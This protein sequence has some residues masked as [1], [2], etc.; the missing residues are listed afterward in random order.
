MKTLQ[1]TYTFDASAQEITIGTFNPI[2]LE[3]VM[4]ITNV[5][6]NII[7]Y[8]FADPT[9]GGTVA[10]DTLTLTY[11]TTSMADGDDLQIWYD[12]VSLS[13]DTTDLATSA[14]QLAAGHT[15]DCDSTDV[16]I[17]NI[18]SDEVFVRG[19]QAAGSPVDNEVVTV[20]GISSMTP[21]IVTESSPI[22]G[23]ATEAKQL[24][25]GHTV[26]CNGTDVTI[27]NISTNEVYVRGGGT[28]GSPTDGEVVVVQGIAGADPVPVTESSPISGFATEAKQLAAGHTVDC[29]GTDVTIDNIS[30]NEV[31]IRG[32]QS[33]GSPVDGEVVTIQGIAGADAV[34]VTESSPI[35]GFATEAKQLAAG[36]TVDCNGTDVTVD[37]ASLTV[38][39]GTASNLKAQVEGT[40]AEGNPIGN[41]IVIA[42][43]TPGGDVQAV[44]AFLASTVYTMPTV[45]VGSTT[46]AN[47]PNASNNELW[48]GG[49]EAHDAVDAGNPIKT[50][51]KAIDYHPDSD[52]E[53]GAAEVAANDRANGAFNRRG[54]IIEG[55]NARYNVLDNVSVVYDDDPTTATSTAIECWNYRQATIGFDLDSLSTPTAILFEVEISLDGTNYFTMTDGPLGAWI[56]DDTVCAT[57]INESLT[58]SIACQKI[59]LKV[60]ATGTDGA[61]KEFEVTNAHIYLRN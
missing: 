8:N 57:E 10:A 24:A 31:F 9:K 35:S 44:T 56:Y 54:Q 60:T 49:G 33:A 61:G 4:L 45:I 18:S 15:V 23:F 1:T 13:G 20:Q 51:G 7:I 52:A 28:A 3:S 41:P 17:D 26:D 38:D 19:S 5:T 2:V 30:S 12:D 39:Q 16:T 59:R 55:I 43:K 50:G 21:V 29:N 40:V 25:A 27:D 14:K 36:H 47:I 46:L 37:N 11:D 6:D 48:V 34:S 32:S 42:G 53:Q 58:F 22:S